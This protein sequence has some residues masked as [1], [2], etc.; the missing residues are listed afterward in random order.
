M[1]KLF[2]IFNSLPA[3]GDFYLTAD[4]FCN[5]FGPRSGSG[6]TKCLASSGSKLFDTRIVLKKF[7]IQRA[8]Y[9]LII[10][11]E[12]II[13]AILE[14]PKADQNKLIRKYVIFEPPTLIKSSNRSLAYSK[15]RQY[16]RFINKIRPNRLDTVSEHVISGINMRNKYKFVFVL[17]AKNF[18][19]QKYVV[20]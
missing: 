3:R 19:C 15:S 12:G 17:C 10:K 1:K 5:Q 6:P 13:K 14:N 7:C 9:D 20:F 2:C 18:V 11:S 4:K 16:V 8:K